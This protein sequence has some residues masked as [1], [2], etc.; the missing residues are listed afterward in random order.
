MVVDDDEA[1]REAFA[2]ILTLN[3]YRV[4]TAPDGL[5]ALEQLRACEQRPEVII[6]DLMMP[7]MDGAQLRQRL[8]EDERLASIPVLI[9]TAAGPTCLGPS[10]AQGADLLRKPIEPAV[11]LDAVSRYC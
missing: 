2:L 4:L 5:R 8:A 6:L 11:L 9:C 1:T 3:G 7:V 10:L